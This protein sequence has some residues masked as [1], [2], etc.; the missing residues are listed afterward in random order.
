VC[1]CGVPDT[2][3]D[4]DQTPDC[5]DGCPNDTYKTAPGVCGCG[6]P[7]TGVDADGIPDCEDHCPAVPNPDQADTDGDDQ[8]NACDPDDDGD[9]AGDAC[10]NVIYVKPAATGL[11]N[12]TRWEDATTLQTAL[13]AAQASDDIWLAAT[14]N[15]GD[16]H[17]P[18]AARTSTFQLR[19]NVSLYGGFAGI[20]TESPAAFNLA[21]R[22][23]TTNQ[24]ILSGDIETNTDCFL[25]NKDLDPPPPGCI[26]RDHGMARWVSPDESGL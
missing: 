21:N 9:G 24:T 2:D 5:V 18:G 14:P 20:E 26:I 17:K 19:N 4:N 22:D 25:G 7:D 8:G 15:P 11:G 23:F 3:S 6:V 12:G 10:E 16:H 1:G 13:T